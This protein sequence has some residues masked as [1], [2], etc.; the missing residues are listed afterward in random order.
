MAPRKK[1]N[2]RA[3][4]SKKTF[5]ATPPDS[6][7]DNYVSSVFP[8]VGIGA[9]A[10]GLDA[11]TEMLRNVPHDSGLAF[12]FIQH[13]EAKTA[14]A[15]PQILGRATSMPVQMAK[16]DEEVAPNTVYVAPANAELT[17][18]RGVLHVGEAAEH[19]S[20]PIDIFLRSLAED[21]GS[22]AIG[23]ILSG[24]ASD[25][26]LGAKAIKAE[27]GITFAQDDSARFDSMPRSAIAGGAVD[28]ILSPKEIS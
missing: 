23:V 8:I 7:L 5:V 26:T 27:G 11:M 19:L 21:Q 25:G 22:R 13:H 12:V 28:F 6:A 3:T 18:A 10:G 17:I 2:K 1:N 15:L 20:M 14:T 9:S 16:N 24:A 4:N